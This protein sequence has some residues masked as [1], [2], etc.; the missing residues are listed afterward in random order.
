MLK[1][2]NKKFLILLLALVVAFNGGCAAVGEQIKAPVEID[3]LVDNGI[4]VKTVTAKNDERF[5]YNYMQIEGLKDQEVQS[6]INKRLKQEFERMA[7]D[8]LPPY[9]GI[10]TQ[11][12]NPGR[13]YNESIDMMVGAN[14]NNVLSILTI[15][16]TTRTLMEGDLNDK[17]IPF[18]NQ[19][20][21]CGDESALTF[22]LNTGEELTLADLFCDN[23]D[24]MTIINDMVDESL[25][26]ANATEEGG[27]SYMGEMGNLILVEP[28]KGLQEDQKFVLYDTGIYLIFD[29]E[30]PQFNVG[31]MPAGLLLDY[32]KLIPNLAITKRFYKEEENL[33]QQDGAPGKR[34]LAKNADND[35]SK[36]Y[37][38]RIGNVTVTKS[39]YYSSQF[40]KSVQK[41]MEDFYDQESD[42]IAEINQHIEEMNA[43]RGDDM[44]ESEVDRF[45]FCD[46]MV[47]ATMAGNYISV[48][49][50]QFPYLPGEGI[51]DSVIEYRT[52][53]ADT[54]KE[55]KPEELF[56]KEFDYQ[57]MIRAW[58]E[59]NDALLYENLSGVGVYD[60][61]LQIV[62][63][64]E[65]DGKRICASA[66]IPY[67]E[68]GS[69]N[70]TIFSESET[71]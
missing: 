40:P 38:E 63:E 26:R 60:A 66:Y 61:G 68:I 51:T 62:T 59:K 21:Y 23:V 16:S 55:I 71:E 14:F 49:Y 11:H 34:L 57:Q 19:S 1:S 44:Q 36:N 54:G 9:R 46:I 30:T 37:S 67:A 3:Y 24:Y 42:L 5:N 2:V 64:T 18:Y 48:E 25:Q 69:N 17:E 47:T 28:F 27:I 7:S 6:K 33:Y 13:I 15:K 53:D 32:A 41:V 43:G 65:Q 10:K 31:F 20:W 39:L 45:G 50:S 8:E 58:A 35:R 70:L 29:Y 56:I 12:Q 22:D 4:T 52:Y